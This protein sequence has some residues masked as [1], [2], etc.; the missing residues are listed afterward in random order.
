MIDM[1]RLEG[2]NYS[3]ARLK[4]RVD[5]IA[6]LIYARTGTVVGSVTQAL[7][8]MNEVDRQV[9]RELQTTPA[10]EGL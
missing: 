7:E 9:D 3:I 5:V 4:E 2:E 1:N 8:I 10:R 6:A